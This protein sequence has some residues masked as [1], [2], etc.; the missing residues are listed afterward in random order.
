MDKGQIDKCLNQRNMSV[1]SL[2]KI[3]SNLSLELETLYA[4]KEEMTRDGAGIVH[5]K[6]GTFL[7]RKPEL[8][9]LDK[10][11][12]TRKITLRMIDDFWQLNQYG[13][14]SYKKHTLIDI[15]Y[16]RKTKKHKFSGTYRWEPFYSLWIHLPGQRDHLVCMLDTNK[17]Y[18]WAYHLFSTAKRKPATLSIFGWMPEHAKNFL[19]ARNIFGLRADD[20][21]TNY[22]TL[23]LGERAEEAKA[24]FSKI[25]GKYTSIPGDC[26]FKL[27]VDETEFLKKFLRNAY[28]F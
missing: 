15:G 23:V 4:Q 6:D 3:A 13:Q 27:A 22:A 11:I 5:K 2:E 14:M 10:T 7:R 20:I 21:C 24:R 28:T 1:E 9:T 12:R 18:G 8:I 26:V 19:L 17:E 25:E 16:D